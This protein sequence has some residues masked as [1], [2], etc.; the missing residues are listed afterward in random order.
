MFKM[1]EPGKSSVS[2]VVQ[3]IMFNGCALKITTTTEITQEIIEITGV[4]QSNQGR[5]HL[6][7]DIGALCTRMSHQ[8]AASLSLARNCAMLTLQNVFN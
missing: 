1:K 6:L 7:R 2:N 8:G 3:M 4:H 5:S